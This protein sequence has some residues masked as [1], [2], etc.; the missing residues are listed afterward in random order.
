MKALLGIIFAFAVFSGLTYV[1]LFLGSIGNAAVVEDKSG[2]ERFTRVAGWVAAVWGV[3][4]VILWMFY[5]SGV[6]E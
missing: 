3:T 1:A 6:L 5:L 4:F 2:A